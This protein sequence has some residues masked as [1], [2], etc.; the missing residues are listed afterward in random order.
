LEKDS[1]SNK[2]EQM[3]L[4][5]LN[6]VS[7]MLRLT[8]ERYFNKVMAAIEKKDD[9]TFLE[10]CKIVGIHKEMGINIWK[11]LQGRDLYYADTWL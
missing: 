10:M 6:N 4:K 11:I 1:E 2:I 9:A 8:D 3:R 7:M 5:T